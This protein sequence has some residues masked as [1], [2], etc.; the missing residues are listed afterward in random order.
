MCLV[1]G[2]TILKLDSNTIIIKFKK[3]YEINKIIDSGK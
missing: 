1:L 2:G 3:M